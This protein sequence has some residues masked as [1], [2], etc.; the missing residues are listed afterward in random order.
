[1]STHMVLPADRLPVRLMWNPPMTDDEYFEFCAANQDVRFERSAKG[2]VII[3]PPAGFESDN[4]NAEV[5]G[6]LW[7]WSKR[8][9]RGHF[10]GPST[11]FFLPTG[12][13]LSPDAAWTLKSRLSKL[14]KSQKRKFLHLSPD[15]VIEVM[16]PT[17]TLRAAKEKMTE[18]IAGGVK[19][20]W[21]I[22]GDHKT[23][24]VYRPS[25]EPRKHIGITKLAG[26]GPVAGFELDLTHIWTGV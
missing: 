17:D 12:A 7:N 25:K 26:E 3:V 6:Q 11:E 13:A 10:S 8:D 2:E 23:V 5:V 16:S 4:R 24:Y 14:S 9:G 1:M 22:D 19:L 20:A 15:F 18:W 21:L